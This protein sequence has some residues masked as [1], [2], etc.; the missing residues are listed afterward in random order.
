M[1]RVSH[2]Q[3]APQQVP[4]DRPLL[5]DLNPHVQRHLDPEQRQHNQ[6]EEPGPGCPAAADFSR[7]AG[8]CSPSGQRSGAGDAR[9]TWGHAGPAS[10][11]RPAPAVAPALAPGAG[12]AQAGRAA[13]AWLVTKPSTPAINPA[14]ARSSSGRAAHPH[15]PRP[16]DCAGVAL[17]V[18]SLPHRPPGP[19]TASPARRT[20]VGSCARKTGIGRRQPRP[21]SH[22]WRAQ[23][24]GYQ[25]Q[26]GS[27]AGKVERATLPA[28]Q[29]PAPAP[30]H[31][32]SAPGSGASSGLG[33]A[34]LPVTLLNTM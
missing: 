6:A 2:H 5:A 3:R 14:V 31:S 24:L 8:A 29:F 15:S 19:G 26:P 18:R 22:T 10:R 32:R 21:A 9:A 11:R 12:P 17:P 34:P 1:R 23:L 20:N 13:P 25:L 28:Q 27:W 16:S 30:S 33:D 4:G 7:R